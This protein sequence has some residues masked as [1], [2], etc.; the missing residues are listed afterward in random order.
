MTL[1]Y[2]VT[3]IN[4]GVT[5]QLRT[6]NGSLLFSAPRH[7][8]D[9]VI[10]Q[11]VNEPNWLAKVRVLQSLHTKGVLNSMPETI[12]KAIISM[13]TLFKCVMQVIVLTLVC[14]SLTE[15]QLVSGVASSDGT[16]SAG[17]GPGSSGSGS[18]GSM[19]GP[20]GLPF[21]APNPSA[22]RHVGIGYNLL[23]GNPDG[24]HWSTGGEDPGTLL[25]KKILYVDPMDPARQLV[26]E[27][28]DNCQTS[29]GFHLFYD[30]KSY[31]DKLFNTVQ[32][33]V[34]GDWTQHCNRQADHFSRCPSGVGDRQEKR[35]KKKRRRKLNMENLQQQGQHG[36]GSV[37]A[38]NYHHK[39]CYQA[40]KTQTSQHHYIFQD[41]STICNM[42]HSRY[43]TNLAAADHFPITR[44]FAASVCSLPT[45]LDETKYMAFIDE[46]GTHII[47]DASIGKKATNRFIGRRLDLFNFVV[48]NVSML[49]GKWGEGKWREEA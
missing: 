27:H 30:T 20:G 48:Q 33:S 19:I 21:M 37:F 10:S 26:V 17:S 7:Y 49:R 3:P 34:Q 6:G 28:H 2:Q 41:A 13:R 38:E 18:V 25:T 23:K 11:A 36:K 22:I 44:E 42:G 32:T 29:H 12:S 14:L 8:E 31:Q 40:L 4:V 35:E 47:I 15:A 39:K 9:Y 43:A 46:W 16:V 45:D 24:E 5:D 1:Q